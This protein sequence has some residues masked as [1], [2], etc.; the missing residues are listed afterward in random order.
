M[1]N[2]FVCYRFLTKI[3]KSINKFLITVEA[4]YYDK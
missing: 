4:N 3:I 2:S 1:H